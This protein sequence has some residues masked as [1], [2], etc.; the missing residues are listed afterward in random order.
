MHLQFHK[1]GHKI[2][3]RYLC[4]SIAISLVNKNTYFE[5]K[6][7]IQRLHVQYDSNL[8]Y[9]KNLQIALSLGGR[10]S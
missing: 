4:F 9:K 7:P 10:G 5:K 6:V 8:T 2:S 3:L 1:K